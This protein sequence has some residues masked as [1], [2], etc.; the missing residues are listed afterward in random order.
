MSS[1]GKLKAHGCG[2][3]KESIQTGWPNG[4]SARFHYGKSEDSN[5][6]RMKPMSY[7]FIL[8]ADPHYW[9]EQEAVE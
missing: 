2:R 6:S 4:L 8:A 7:K 5:P 3:Y 9:I 1:D